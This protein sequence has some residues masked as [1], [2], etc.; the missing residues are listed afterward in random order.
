M[1]SVNANR[2]HELSA[3]ERGDLWTSSDVLKGTLAGQIYWDLVAADRIVELAALPAVEPVGYEPPEDRTPASVEHWLINTTPG[4]KR[5]VASYF[6]SKAAYQ[7]SLID[8]CGA[9]AALE[10][11]S[12]WQEA[13]DLDPDTVYVGGWPR[14]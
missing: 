3:E 10:A 6:R 1:T 2:I 12:H 7:R 4:R 14:P 11:A 8:A 5:E 13:E 9:W